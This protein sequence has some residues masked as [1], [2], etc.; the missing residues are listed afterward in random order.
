M[1]TPGRLI[2]LLS[3]GKA[4]KPITLHRLQFLIFDEADRMLELGFEEQLKEIYNFIHNLKRSSMCSS[5]SSSSSKE[6]HMD[7]RHNDFNT[8][9]FTATLPKRLNIFV[10]SWIQSPRIDISTKGTLQNIGNS[11]LGISL[12][13]LKLFMFVLNTK[14][15]KII[16][17]LKHLKTM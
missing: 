13:S 7:L 17:F 12:L 3:I 8:C 10:N 6:H 11:Q 1:A 5:S 2:D 4:N 9:M 14:S 16:K 15:Q